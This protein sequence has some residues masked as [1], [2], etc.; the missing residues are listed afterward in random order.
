[1]EIDTIAPEH[2]L[3]SSEVACLLQVNASSIKKWVD[4]GHLQAFRT[5]GGHRRIRALDLIAFLDRHEIPVPASLREAARRRVVVVDDD[6]VQL[7]A[8]ARRL[9][10]WSAAI[11]VEAVDDPLDALVRIG[12]VQPHAVIVDLLMPRLSG[13][14]LC[15]ALRHCEETR[16]ARVIAVSASLSAAMARDALA[17]GAHHAVAKPLDPAFVLNEVGIAAESRR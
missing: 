2:L 12:R 11:D 6:K 3:T 5:P 16:A 7:R 15:R 13:L 4:S 10:R 14:E 1:V 9:K 17:A 8:L